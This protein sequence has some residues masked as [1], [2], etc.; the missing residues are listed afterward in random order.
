MEYKIVLIN[1]TAKEN[2]SW[3][4]ENYSS[5]K[6]IIFGLLQGSEWL[7][8]RFKPGSIVL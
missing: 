8:K 1:L 3:P 7:L 2:I 4:N 5:Q 6:V